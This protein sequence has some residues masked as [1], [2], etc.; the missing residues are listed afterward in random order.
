[1]STLTRVTCLKSALFFFSD[2]AQS[3]LGKGRSMK[4]YRR[5]GCLAS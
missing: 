3:V 1:L 5:P 2:P 4:V